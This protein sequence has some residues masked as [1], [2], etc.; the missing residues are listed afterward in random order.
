MR[1]WRG[2]DGN[3]KYICKIMVYD[4]LYKTDDCELRRCLSNRDNRS[5]SSSSFVIITFIGKKKDEN[6]KK[7]DIKL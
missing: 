1:G 7:Y 2:G 6:D 4:V 3:A 5:Q